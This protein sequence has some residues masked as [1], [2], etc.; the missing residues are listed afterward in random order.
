LEG[1]GRE[2]IGGD[3]DVTRTVGWFTSM[4]PVTLDMQFKQDAI[5]QLIETKE[6]LHRVPNK[7]IGYGLLRYLAKKPYQLQPQI[8]FNYLGDFGS[9]TTTEEGHQLFNFSSDFHG[10][11]NS[12]NMQRSSVL[13]INAMVANGKMTINIAFSK[14]QYQP[15]TMEKLGQAYAEKLSQLIEKL[16]AEENVTLTPVDFAYQGLSMEDLDKLNKMLGN[17]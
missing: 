5:R 10:H 6:A 1:H 14:N 7:G 17:Q 4:Y 15:A 8:A 16:S 12:P 9:G 2:N 11:F 13:E 3:E